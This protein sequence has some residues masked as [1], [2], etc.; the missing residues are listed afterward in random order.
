MGSSES[1]P[2][3]LSQPDVEISGYVT[4]IFPDIL[5]SKVP[6]VPKTGLI[7][8]FPGNL[9]HGLAPSWGISYSHSKGHDSLSLPLLLTSSKHQPRT[10][11]MAL[12]QTFPSS[13][14]L[15]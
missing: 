5:A 12:A 3:N 7:S 9:T 6:K 15:S 14:S 2:L 4:Q 11:V 1:T 10:A 8:R 13:A